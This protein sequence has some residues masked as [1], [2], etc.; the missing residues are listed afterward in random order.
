MLDLTRMQLGI[1][2]DGDEPG[3]PAT[4]ETLEELAAILH[5]ENHTVA[6]RSAAGR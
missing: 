3:R 6:R 2:R 4:I 1:A 5:P